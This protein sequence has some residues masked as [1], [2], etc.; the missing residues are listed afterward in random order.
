MAAAANIIA[1]PPSSLIRS[2]G[3]Q[4]SRLL[5]S[6]TNGPFRSLAAMKLKSESMDVPRTCTC[7][8]MSLAV[9]HAYFL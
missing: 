9:Y 6:Q 8:C 1:Y 3:R 5:E 7:T 4:G 2:P